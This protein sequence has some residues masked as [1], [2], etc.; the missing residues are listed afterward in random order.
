MADEFVKM[1]KGEETIEVH[2]SVVADHESL[3]W[4]VVA[5]EPVAAETAADEAPAKK[6]K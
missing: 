2:P 6:K 1:T 5:A 4:T 3:G